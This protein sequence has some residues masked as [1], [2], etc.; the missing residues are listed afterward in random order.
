MA[1]N[2][3]RDAQGKTAVSAVLLFIGI[4]LLPETALSQEKEYEFTFNPPDGLTYVSS[5]RSVIRKKIEKGSRATE[6]GFIQSRVQVT[7]TAKGYAFTSQTLDMTI[8]RDGVK[9]EDPIAELLR[10][11]P[12]TIEVNS[13][14]RIMEMKGY[15]ELVVK[16]KEIIS[17]QAFQ[18]LAETLSEEALKEKARREWNEQYS[19]LLFRKVKAADRWISGEEWHDSSGRTLGYVSVNTIEGLEPCGPRDC[20]RISRRFLS[21]KDAV[22]KIAGAEL[23]KNTTDI[24]WAA[25]TAKN[26]GATVFGQGYLVIEPSTMLIHSEGLT[27]TWENIDIIDPIQGRQKGTMVE[28]KDYRCEL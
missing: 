17:Q 6:E 21:D 1:E 20:L 22:E 16:I 10:S 14:A 7:K 24:D 11:I 3:L 25:V 18:A 9:V 13:Y 12:I 27:R 15:D 8:H 2:F 5:A 19:G 23:V 26:E 4:F 28:K